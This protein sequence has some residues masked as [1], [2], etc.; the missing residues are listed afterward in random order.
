VLHLDAGPGSIELDAGDRA[1]TVKSR[2]VID[3]D[4]LGPYVTLG[5][6]LAL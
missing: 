1:S 3:A 2:Q 6:R 4:L 5:Y